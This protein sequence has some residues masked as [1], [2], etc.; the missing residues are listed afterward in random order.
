MLRT[1]IHDVRERRECIRLKV[2]VKGPNL[3]YLLIAGLVLVTTACTQHRRTP[4]A[5]PPTEMQPRTHVT[6][7]ERQ[8]LP[9]HIAPPPAYG[10]KVV[11]ASGP[12]RFGS[13]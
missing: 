3:S 1:L 8:D 11:M 12:A 7:E 6:P 5:D 2:R 4:P 13:L 9:P 10:N